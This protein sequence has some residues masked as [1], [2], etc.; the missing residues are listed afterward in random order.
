MRTGWC[1]SERNAVRLAQAAQSAG[2][3]MVTVHG[4]TREQGYQGHAEY[5]TIAAVKAALRIPVVANGDIDS[6]QKARD[7]LRY[8]RADAIMVGR[9]AQGR[10]WIFQEMAHFL[11]HSELPAPPWCERSKAGFW[12]IFMTT[13]AFMENGRAC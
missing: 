13:I 5:D 10:P 3:S 4:R 7:V 9:A 6:P 2:V 11:K 8:T 1:A 12:S